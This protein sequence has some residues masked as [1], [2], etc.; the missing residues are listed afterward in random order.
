[1]EVKTGAT[2]NP[3]KAL[4]ARSTISAVVKCSPLTVTVVWRSRSKPCSAKTSGPET[5]LRAFRYQSLD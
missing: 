1:M 5:S 3:Q 2:T 4:P